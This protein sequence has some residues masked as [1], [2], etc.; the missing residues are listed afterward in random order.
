M[1]MLIN[2]SRRSVTTQALEEAKT[3]DRLFVASKYQLF[4]L[5]QVRQVRAHACLFR[6]KTEFCPCPANAPNKHAFDVSKYSTAVLYVYRF[7]T[8]PLASLGR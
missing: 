8:P 6:S 1:Q 7:T 4:T 3:R 5:N 2:I